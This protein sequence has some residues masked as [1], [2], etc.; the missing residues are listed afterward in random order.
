LRTVTNCRTRRRGTR[1]RVRLEVPWHAGAGS[2]GRALRSLERGLAAAAAASV[3]AGAG[4]AAGVGCEPRA[5]VAG[6]GAVYTAPLIVSR[7]R[8]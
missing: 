2:C 1:R 4:A 7:D 8:D 6:A 3:R 5:C